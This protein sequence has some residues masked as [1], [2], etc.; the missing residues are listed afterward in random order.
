MGITRMVPALPVTQEATELT[1]LLE[2]A[3]HGVTTVLATWLG[4]LVVTRAGRAPGAPVFSF[5]CLL[6]VLW[7]VAIIV[8][9]TG[10]DP[11]VHPT[12]NLIEDASAFLLPGATLHIALAVAIEGRRSALATALLVAGYVVGG[13]G[14]IQ[15][16]VD[17]AHPIGFSQPGFS[18]LG[19]S[20]IATAW[21]FALARALVFGSGIVYLAR[22]LRAAGDDRARRRQLLFA[23]ATMVLGVIGG[24]ARILPEEIG[25]PRFVGVTIVAV[26]MVLATYAVLSQHMFVAADV[27]GRAVRWSLAAGL[28]IVAYV[29]A[30][31]LLEGAAAKVLAIDF[32]LVTTL[33]VIVTLALFDP[34]TERVRQI[35]GGT[36][37]EVDHARLLV[38]LGKDAMLAQ[39]P[40][41]ALEPALARLVRTFDLV[42]AELVDGDGTT[43]AQA[44][45]IDRTDPLGVRLDLGDDDEVHAAA[46]FGRKRNGLSFT[47][48]ERDALALAA[49]YLGSSLRLAE[50]HHAQASA[51]AELRA[52]RAD[53]QSRGSALSVA[54]ADA[55][56]PAPG[57]HV[58]ALGSLRAELNGE[59]VRRW[60]G[61]K[62]GSRQ[63]EA[64]FAFL[65]D[66][67]DRGAS[68][69]EI[70]ELVWPDVD[71]DRA[72]VAFHRTMLGLRSSLNPGRRTRVSA[73][74]IV[75]HNDRYRLDPSVVAW[76]DVGEFDR[77]LADAATGDPAH[78]LRAL[79]QAR[80]LYRGDFLDDCPFYG[81]SAPVEDRRTE[82]RRRYVDVLI[83]LGERYALRGDRAAAANSYRQAQAV[84]D[85]DLPQI[86]EALGQLAGQR[87]TGSA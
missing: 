7:S 43:R 27:A 34:I 80:A 46:V 5:L 6:L 87:P 54:L 84:A 71:L 68:K 44:G 69:D 11:S 53:V 9:R 25:G 30:L 40:E 10:N 75:F 26:A 14:I 50:R 49:S 59:P 86:T 17:P 21:G 39:E 20:Y 72:D 82:L 48:P 8:Q 15:A 23:L 65:F 64:I 41:Q 67:G 32:P 31:V 22:G 18:L 66:R 70:L 13:L 24:M 3:A 58:F 1:E 45:S 73:G 57:L 81:D 28:G 36:P 42:G 47:P 51:L 62:A 79:E 2:I 60:G 29:G 74:P 16:V 63:A 52:E 61:E 83:E 76:S 38:A 4:L 85:D 77:L 55:S 35:T 78:S 12:V 33:A 19:L 37:R 56:T